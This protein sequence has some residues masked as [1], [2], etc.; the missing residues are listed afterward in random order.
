[1]M[2]V[3]SPRHRSISPAAYGYSSRGVAR[4]SRTAERAE[5]ELLR[6]RD[7]EVLA[8]I[9]EQY[10]G[11]IDHLEVL[12]GAGPRTVQR[13]LARLRAAG[14]IRTQRVLVGEPAWVLPTAAGMTACSSGFGVWRPRIGLLNHV[15]AVNDV[16]LHIQGRAPGTEWLPERVLARDRLAGEHLP[17]GVAITDGRRVAI[18]AELTLKSRRRITANLD[19]LTVRFDAVL[20]FCATSTHR[21]LTELA[22]SGRWPTLGVRELPTSMGDDQERRLP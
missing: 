21:Q 1:M 13:T 3:F 20:Y 18:E 4:A 12:L 15:A 19:D 7:I 17:D 16:R 14:L 8:W 9:A 6:R 22:A 2:R 11:R 10:A 5:H